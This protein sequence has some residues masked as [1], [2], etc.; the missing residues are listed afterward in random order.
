[1]ASETSA[2]SPGQVQQE[3]CCPLPGRRRKATPSAIRP[4]TAAST[5]AGTGLSLAA[6]VEG[7]VPASQ[8]GAVLKQAAAGRSGCLIMMVADAGAAS[9]ATAIIIPTRICNCMKSPTLAASHN[10]P[11]IATS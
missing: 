3:T 8:P 6:S 10:S 9:A 5:G 7:L 11:K 1:M 2:R 4:M